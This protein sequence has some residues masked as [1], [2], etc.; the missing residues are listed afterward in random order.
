MRNKQVQV[1][2]VGIGGYGAT[3]VK[4]MLHDIREQ[5]AVLAGVVDVKPELS[6]FYGELAA[7]GIPMYDSLESFYANRPGGADL[8]VISTPIQYHCPQT[9]LALQHGSHVLVE[10]PVSATVQEAR[11]MMEAERE[12][13]GPFVAVGYN[14]SFSSQIQQL[15]RDIQSGL[16][17]RPQR[18]RTLVL[19]RRT[20]DYFQKG[21][22]GRVK[23]PQGDWILDSVAHNAT[24]HYLHNMF[25][26]LGDDTEASALPFRV[27]AELYRANPIENFDTCA[28]RAEVEGGVELLF[29]ASHAVTGVEGPDF[30][31]EFE[32]AV[33]SYAFGQDNEEIK[34][35]FQ[36]GTEKRYPKAG[37]AYFLGTGEQHSAVE[38]SP[39]EQSKLLTCIQAVRTGS[40]GILCGLKAAYPQV[41]CMNGMLESSAVA[42]FPES[43]IRWAEPERVVWVEGLKEALRQCYEQGRLP[44]ELGKDWAVPGRW[45]ELA[46]YDSFE[47]GCL[48]P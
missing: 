8:V 32:R 38:E 23:S 43:L 14:W 46:T 18:L 39:K 37:G 29:L 21:W 2:I 30:T 24:S 16:F 15:K 12:A 27:Q 48:Q 13:A 40:A 7:A 5:D 42:D 20:Q 6:R 35:V 34:A 41:L 25:Y 47:G 9:C 28:V 19:W 3:H 22:K 36:D 31:F 45:V 4:E 44:S 11:R 33:I 1:V 26:L 10:K 17:G